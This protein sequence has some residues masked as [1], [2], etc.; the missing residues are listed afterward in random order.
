MASNRKISPHQATID[1]FKKAQKL[2]MSG[3]EDT[4]KIIKDKVDTMGTDEEKKQFYEAFNKGNVQAHIDS[5]VNQIKN[6][7]K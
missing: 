1:R 6:Q 7:K 5:L 3:L 2:I 4:V